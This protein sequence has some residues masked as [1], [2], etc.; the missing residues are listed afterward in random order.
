MR[1]GQLY[2]VTTVLENRP[3]GVKP[4]AI[5]SFRIAFHGRT[6]GAL[7]ATRSKAPHKLDLPLYEWPCA[8]FP[9][10]RYPLEQHEAYNHK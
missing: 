4:F 5:P 9:N 10:Y 6:F 2:E 1:G 8:D 3:L 7:S